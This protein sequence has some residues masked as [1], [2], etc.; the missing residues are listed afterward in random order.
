LKEAMFL[1]RTFKT[2]KL[3]SFTEA[4]D[5]LQ[6]F[7]ICGCRME[8]DSYS[9]MLQPEFGAY[10]P[11]PQADLVVAS[12][13]QLGLGEKART[14]EIY[15]RAETLGLILCPATVGPQLRWQYSD[16]PRGEVLNIAMTPFRNSFGKTGVFAVVNGSLGPTLVTLSCEPS[17][18][19]ASFNKWVFIRPR[20]S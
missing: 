8:D 20:S 5:F 6:K 7:K 11:G 17:D 14:Q 4:S 3:G 15:E 19:W 9:M 12:C 16:Q 2:I 1:F 13:A 18:F 10:W